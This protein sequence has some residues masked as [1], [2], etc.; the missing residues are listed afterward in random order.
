MTIKLPKFLLSLIFKKH[1]YRVLIK[2][3][4][5]R[6]VEI[7]V[8]PYEKTYPEYPPKMCSVY[9]GIVSKLTNSKVIPVILV[10]DE[11][12]EIVAHFILRDKKGFIDCSVNLETLK[13]VRYFRPNPRVDVIIND[14]KYDYR[15]FRLKYSLAKAY[16]KHC[17]IKWK[18]WIWTHIP[19]PDKISFF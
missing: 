1:I 6:A 17:K 15:L 9:T 14:G 11:H 16:E 7:N 10:D 12:K 8:R 3:I 4:E 18:R 2:E 5:N 19:I 13:Q